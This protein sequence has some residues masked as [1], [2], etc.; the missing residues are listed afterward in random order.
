MARNTTL[1]RLLDMYRAECKM[2][3]NVAH[4]NQDR[5]R[6]VNQLQMTQEWLWEDFD[7]PLLRVDRQINLASGQRYYSPPEDIH[8]DRIDRVEVYFDA[9]YQRLH[10]GIDDNHYTAYNS[11]LDQRQWPPQR[12]RISED[13]QMEIW[14]VPDGNS[15]LTT[16]EGTVR[17]TGIRKLKPLVAD[18]DR[19]DLDDQL[20]VLWAAAE[21]LASSGDKAANLKLEKAKSRYAKLRG[22]QIPRKKFRMFGV[23]ERDN[24]RRIPIAVY[25]KT[26]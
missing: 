23:G 13:E 1:S 24:F 16:L 7:W 11:A 22:A 19:A 8:I 6:Q 2:S 4:N 15:D 14:P 20:I 3:L 12:W 21:T 26:G 17:V 5:D 10:P 9:A 18:N 25:N